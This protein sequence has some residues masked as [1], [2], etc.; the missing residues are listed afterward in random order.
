MRGGGVDLG[1]LIAPRYTELFIKALAP[2]T[3]EVTAHDVLKLAL[4]DMT[5]I[6]HDALEHEPIVLAGKQRPCGRAPPS[7]R[8]VV[9]TGG[10]TSG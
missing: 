3:G 4:Q 5:I 10:G 2:G 1:Q 6:A 8:E 9:S 7:A